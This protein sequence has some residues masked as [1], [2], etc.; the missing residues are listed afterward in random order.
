MSIKPL[1]SNRNIYHTNEK[2]LSSYKKTGNLRIRN[3]IIVNNMG[4]VYAAAKKRLHINSSLAFDDLVQEGTIGMI[5]GIE[6]FDLNRNTRFSTYAYYWINQQMDR[7]IMNTGYL[8]RLPTY[9]YERI[10]RL[11]SMEKLYQDIDKGLEELIEDN[12][13]SKDEYISLNYYRNNYCYFSSL[14]IVIDMDNENSYIELQ[15]FIPP[16]DPT[17]EDIIIEKDLKE[18]IDNTLNMLTAKEKDIIESRF[19]IKTGEIETLEE[20]G[21]RYNLTR[22]RI[23]QIEMKALKKLR[24]LESENDLEEFLSYLS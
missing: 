8:I 16:K 9:I 14:N 1:K 3:Q 12:N 17:L 7:A 10:S 22:E 11:N 6:R 18:Q 2:L 15:D 4:L 19:G 24:K 13:M 20:I 23:R 21:G 5:K